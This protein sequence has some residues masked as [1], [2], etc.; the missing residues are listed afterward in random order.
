MRTLTLMILA[1]V[2]I[3]PAASSAKRDRLTDEQRLE[4]AL[5]GL[6]PGK[7]V[8]CIELRDAQ[9]TEA[10]GDTLLFRSGRRLIYRNDAPGCDG[11]FAETFVTRTHGTRLCRGDVITKVDLQSGFQHG[12]CIAKSFTPYRAATAR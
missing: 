6:Q 3:L 2:A 9:G 1:G 5:T 7:P 12:F 8:D 4:K 10:F 11:G